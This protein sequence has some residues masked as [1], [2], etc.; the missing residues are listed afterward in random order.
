MEEAARNPIITVVL[1]VGMHC[2]GCASEIVHSAR[3]LKGV[4]RVKVNID[5]NELIVVGQVDPLQIQEDLSRK[6]KKKVELVSPQPKNGE[7]I[8][9]LTDKNGK[10]S[11]EE[12]LC[13]DKASSHPKNEDTT[14][15]NKDYDKKSNDK[16][17][18]IIHD[19]PKEAVVT[20]TLVLKLGH[21]CQGCSSKI[22]KTVLNTKEE[23]YST[24]NG[25]DSEKV[26]DHEKKGSEQEN[27]SDDTEMKG[28]IMELEPQTAS[29]TMAVFK[30]PLHCDGCTK[31]I[32]K[33]ISRIRGVLEVRIN[34]EEE[35]V[36]VISTIDG[37]ALTETMKKR[38]KKLVDEKK[39]EIRKDAEVIKATSQYTFDNK[40][41]KQQSSLQPALQLSEQQSEIIEIISVHDLNDEDMKRHESPVSSS[42]S[43]LTKLDL[44]IGE[45]L[46]TSETAEWAF[47]IMSLLLEGVS[48][49][50]D[51]LGRLLGSMLLAF[52]ALLLSTV[53][54]IY[55]ARREGQIAFDRRS[56]LPCYFC[57]L[58]D[59]T[60][61]SELFSVIH[62]F[63]LTCAVW[64][65]LFST[66]QYIYALRHL[67]NPIKMSL[68]PFIFLVCVLISKSIRKMEKINCQNL[69]TARTKVKPESDVS[70][71][72]DVR[73]SPGLKRME[74][75]GQALKIV[76]TKTQVPSNASEP[77]DIEV[78]HFGGSEGGETEIEV[79]VADEN[80]SDSEE[81][82]G[83]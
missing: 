44:E 78:L 76:E 82:D 30:V 2:E 62:C 26:S 31:K 17:P 67:D 74:Q 70:Q 28:S 39:I 46:S 59:K 79:E 23:E 75:N 51:Q 25:E 57:H 77:V 22:R 80:E 63:A 58:K 34:R 41:P 64:Q 49:V 53:E 9:T 24:S 60:P 43:A 27:G 11:N 13:I 83:V 42:G 37:K 50:L 10:Q 7:T 81:K 15:G 47:L 45:S 38:L 56:E 21:Y 29:A 52:A 40:A 36:T 68:L 48:A 16:N 54:L 35:T 61:T 3:G 73:L 65:C 71:C 6:I 66:V 33:I 1:E 5:S 18:D 8:T 12:R 69:N 20:T 72:G 4:E 32:R 14:T 55:M 19:K